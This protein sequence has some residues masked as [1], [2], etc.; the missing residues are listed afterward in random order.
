MKLN[1]VEHSLDYL[2]VLYKVL[3]IFYLT[4]YVETIPTT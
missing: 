1:K 2:I 4:T 3:I